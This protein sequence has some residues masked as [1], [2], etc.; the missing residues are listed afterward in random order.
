[1]MAQLVWELCMVRGEMLERRWGGQGGVCLDLGKYCEGLTVGLNQTIPAGGGGDLPI[2][3]SW[4]SS[5][6]SATCL[7][8]HA[9]HQAHNCW[10]WLVFRPL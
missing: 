4:D 6:F 8:L 3:T 10:V 2:Y 1:M 7:Q 9:G 5:C